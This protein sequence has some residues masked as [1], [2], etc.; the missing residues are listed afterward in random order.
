MNTEIFYKFEV[1][2]IDAV[3]EQKGQISSLALSSQYAS[4]CA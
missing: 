1:D 3:E 4:C 2:Y